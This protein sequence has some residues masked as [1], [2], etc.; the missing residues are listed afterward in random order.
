MEYHCFIAWN[1]RIS[2]FSYNALI[3]CYGEENIAIAKTKWNKV[4]TKRLLRKLY[5]LRMATFEEK[6]EL[7]DEDGFNFFIC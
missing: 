3:K 5:G 2:T 1:Q 7:V 6:S 4:D